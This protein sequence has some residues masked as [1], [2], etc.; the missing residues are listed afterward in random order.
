[1][2]CVYVLQGMTELPDYKKIQ[3][4]EMQAI[5]MEQ[6]L[7][8]AAP[9]VRLEIMFKVAG[10]QGAFACILPKQPLKK[11]GLGCSNFISQC[12]KCRLSHLH[13]DLTFFFLFFSGS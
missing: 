2:H 10:Q 7:P 12:M 11:S 8:D 6:Y 9:D 1:M 3:F 4:R 5:P 13:V